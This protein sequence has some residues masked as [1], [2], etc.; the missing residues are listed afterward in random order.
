MPKLGSLFICAL[1][2]Y[3][4]ICDGVVP[5]LVAVRSHD[6]I[7]SCTFCGRKTDAPSCPRSSQR[8]LE[9]LTIDIYLATAISK[10]ILLDHATSVIIG[11]TT[12]VSD[13]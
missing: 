8:V 9:V 1:A 5:D 11:E 12:I 10:S 7:A 3:P 13:K 2:A 6:L 4:T